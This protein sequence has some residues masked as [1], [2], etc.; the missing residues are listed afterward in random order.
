M[1]NAIKFTPGSKV[2]FVA[3]GYEGGRERVGVVLGI[4]GNYVVMC[5]LDGEDLSGPSYIEQTEIG[6]L[7][8]TIAR[9]RLPGSMAEVRFVPS[10]NPAPVLDS[11][12]DRVR[13]AMN[14]IG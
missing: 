2:V 14:T 11:S 5:M 3:G 1:S 12:A 7:R 13:A 8:A 6:T 9:G 10:A 4:S